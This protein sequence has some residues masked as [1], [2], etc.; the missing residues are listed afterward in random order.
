MRVGEA[1]AL[2]RADLD[3]RHGLLV[4][5]H[6]K[7]NKSRELVLHP[8]TVAAL[9]GYLR[10]RER[11]HP[12]PSS[13]ALLISTAGT[14]LRYCNVHWTFHRL[15]QEAGLTPRSASCRPR[16]TTSALLRGRL[17]ARRLRRRAEDG[18]VRLTLLSTYLG[19]VDPAGTYWYLSASPELLALAGQRLER[20]AGGHDRA[21][22]DPAGVLHRRLIRQRNASGHTIAAYRDALR[23]LLAYAADQL[24]Q[25]AVPAGR[26]RARRAD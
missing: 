2:D 1:I 11:L 24:R 4:V 12:N 8:S 6:G 25:P 9:R 18:Q 13:P 5:R 16:S 14:R 20:R 23:L 7:F 22:S 21:A 19:H 3:Q 10:E 15:V 17:D 26:R